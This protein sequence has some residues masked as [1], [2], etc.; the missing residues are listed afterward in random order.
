MMTRQ[1]WLIALVA[2]VVILVFLALV[3]CAVL[4]IGAG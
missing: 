4:W 3:L 1:D 2:F